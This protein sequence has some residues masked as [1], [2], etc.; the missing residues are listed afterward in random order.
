MRVLASLLS[1]ESLFQMRPVN[2]VWHFS[3]E[4]ENSNGKYLQLCKYS[5]MGESGE[6]KTRINTHHSL[7]CVENCRKQKL[8]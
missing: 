1:S 6:N 5:E 7:M 4:E 2:L 3:H 8:T